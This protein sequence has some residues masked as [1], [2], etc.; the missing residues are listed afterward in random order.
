MRAL[1]RPLVAPG[2]LT[3]IAGAR[4][5]RYGL[6]AGQRSEARV[7]PSQ[8]GLQG[9]DLEGLIEDEAAAFTA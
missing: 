8:K 3:G 9:V 5:S 1:L 4:R 6:G 7:V 2:L